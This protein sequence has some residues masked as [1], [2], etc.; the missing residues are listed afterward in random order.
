MKRPEIVKDEHLEHLDRLSL[1]REFSMK[2]AIEYLAAVFN[3]YVK[4]AKEIYRYWRE[5]N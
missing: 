1:T 4:D 3:L 2:A 5:L